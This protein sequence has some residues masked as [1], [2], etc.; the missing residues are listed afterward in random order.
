MANVS[1]W[2][3][4]AHVYAMACVGGV[5]SLASPRASTFAMGAKGSAEESTDSVNFSMKH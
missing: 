4:S 3:N 5:P 1:Q 2:L